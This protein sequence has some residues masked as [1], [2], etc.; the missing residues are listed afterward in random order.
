M[1]DLCKWMRAKSLYGRDLIS[2][3]ELT[4]LYLMN[5]VPWSCNR[6]A[7]STGPDDA[8]CEPGACASGRACFEP[9]P[10]LV[11]PLS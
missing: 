6:T 3:D 10:K 11:R 2:E 5:D 4:A 7:R 1:I 9:S 8:L